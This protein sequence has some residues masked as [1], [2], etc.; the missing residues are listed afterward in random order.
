MNFSR[1][2]QKGVW[3]EF[4]N[5]THLTLG[6]RSKNGATTK[7]CEMSLRPLITKVGTRT[8]CS[9]STIVQFLRILPEQL[10]LSNQARVQTTEET[11]GAVATVMSPFSPNTWSRE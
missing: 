7:S 6:I 11:H 3:L 9:R 5:V 10:T 1:S 2:S 8:R 4:S